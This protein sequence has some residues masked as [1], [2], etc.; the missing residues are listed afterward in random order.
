MVALEVVLV[1]RPNL[2]GTNG[3]ATLN[4]SCRLQFLYAHILAVR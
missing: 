1:S 2:N 3:P 4:G